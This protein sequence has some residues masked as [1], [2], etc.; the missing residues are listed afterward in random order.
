MTPA[1]RTKSNGAIAPKQAT[2]RAICV[3]DHAVLVEGLKAHFAIDGRIEVVSRLP[4]AAKLL[5]E[6]RR[7]GP[8]VVLLDIE[9]PGPD[10]FEVAA[11]LTRSQPGVRVIFLSAHIRHGYISASFAAGASAY[12]AKSDELEDIVQ[13]IKDV[14]E[15]ASATFVLGPKVRELCKP[16]SVWRRGPQAPSA[17][18]RSGDT[19]PAS[20][21]TRLSGLTV[22]EAEILR[23]IGKGLSR[24]EIAEQLTRSV[25]TI[26]GHQDRIMKKLGASSRAEL[27]RFAIREGLAEV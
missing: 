20:P 2:I 17:G 26:D 18:A 10:V 19:V 25:K 16:A 6:T 14:V 7:H 27:I 3:D 12:F 5:E 8:D 24:V 4:S 15:R 21:E 1:R 23:L 22:R 11:T 9:M 13:G